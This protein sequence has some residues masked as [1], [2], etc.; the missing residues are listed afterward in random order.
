[1]VITTGVSEYPSRNAAYLSERNEPSGCWRSI[2]HAAPRASDA[3]MA[4][5]SAGATARSGGG[6]GG[7]GAAAQLV[8]TA[9]ARIRTGKRTGPL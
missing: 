9:R 2:S 6:G 8:S 4:A 1:M 5:R 3:S 7:L